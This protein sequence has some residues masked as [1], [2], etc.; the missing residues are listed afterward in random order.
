M[1]QKAV[2]SADKENDFIDLSIYMSGDA[3]AC[4][5]FVMPEASGMQRGVAASL[6]L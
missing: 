3:V 2:V 4:V 1:M 6:H 5:A